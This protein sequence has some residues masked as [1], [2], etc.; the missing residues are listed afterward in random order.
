MLAIR[1]LNSLPSL[2]EEFFNHEF[3]VSWNR[4]WT[5]ASTP[6]VNIVEG[7]DEYR[8]EVAAPG[9][10]K[11]DFKINLEN[12]LLTISAN[13]EESKEE[14]DEQYTRR[15]FS[16]NSFSRTFTLPDFVEGDK[17][18]AEHKK[19]IL[20]I[21]VPKREEAKIKPAMEIAIA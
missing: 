7:K 9:L 10:E 11:K 8:I 18:S 21:H 16:Y 19:G 17:I 4:N 13:K 2:V 15:E 5:T 14:K 12:D 3:P 6:A 20:S 1:N